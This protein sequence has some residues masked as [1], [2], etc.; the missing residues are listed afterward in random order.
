MDRIR[1]FG[2]PDLPSPPS[3]PCTVQAKGSCS[4]GYSSRKAP[5]PVEALKQMLFSL[6][7]V[8]QQVSQPSAHQAPDTAASD[9]AASDTRHTVDEWMDRNMERDA[10]TAQVNVKRRTSIAVVT[11]Y[12]WAIFVNT[13]RVCFPDDLDQDGGLRHSSWRAVITEV[14]HEACKK[15]RPLTSLLLSRLL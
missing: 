7:A 11:V 8:E 14:L 10:E 12:D 2:N 4:S 5:G 6:Q 9:T 13:Y 15:G 1:Y 3:L